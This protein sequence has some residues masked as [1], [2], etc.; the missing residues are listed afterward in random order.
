[1]FTV[2]PSECCSDVISKLPVKLLVLAQTPPPHHGQ[3]I[4]VE[5]LVNGLPKVAP[6]I[7]LHH[8]NLSLSRQS[9]DIGRW[10]PGKLLSAWRST[11]TAIRTARRHDCDA[12]YYVPAPGKR[13]ALW[14]DLLIL[15]RLRPIVPKLILHWHASGLGTWLQ[16]SATPL[17]R[18]LAH[19]TLDRADLSIVLGGALRQDCQIFQP[20]Q[21]T[22]IPNGIADP[23]HG[24]TPPVRL[25]RKST[26]PINLLFLGSGSGAK[27]LFRAVDALASTPKS[28]TLTF[29]GQFAS[30]IDAERFTAAQN[31]WGAR[32][33]HVGFVSGSAKRNLLAKSD[34]LIF[35]ST[36]ANEAFPLV[37]LEA[38]AADLPILTTP[39]R[40]IPEM[41]PPGS[42]RWA[43]VSDDGAALGPTILQLVAESAES[44]LHRQHF[45][46]HYTLPEH[47]RRISQTLAGV[48][49]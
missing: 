9:T 29:A 30:P 35:P 13:I 18:K 42:K 11:N 7:E 27:G 41:K 45:L 34:L 44:G 6:E 17:E 21:T 3:S 47:L 5:S 20:R 46:D 33:I 40:A 19:A 31:R 24:R 32:L 14:R 22:I 1:V 2:L 48:L 49:S 10:Q 25:P 43:F 36:Y 16:K 23:F 28:V 8:V 12:L 37:L 39:W 26:D 4:M 15:H 38:L